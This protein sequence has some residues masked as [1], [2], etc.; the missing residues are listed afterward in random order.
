MKGE[1]TLIFVYDQPIYS[2]RGEG[3]KL[4]FLTFPPRPVSRGGPQRHSCRLSPLEA[5]YGPRR[6]GRGAPSGSSVV[7]S[8]AKVSGSCCPSPFA[9]YTLVCV[10]GLRSEGVG[11]RCRSADAGLREERGW[12]T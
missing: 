6:N 9:S 10:S 5:G 3:G 12:Q 7:V 2:F 8:S 4:N 11:Q 1:A